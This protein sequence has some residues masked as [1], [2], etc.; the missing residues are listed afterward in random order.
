MPSMTMKDS[1]RPDTIAGAISGKVTVNSVR[2]G[3]TPAISAASSRLGSMF[4]S[5]DAVN[6]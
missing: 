4:R 2:N 5:A 6:M 1:S 3:L